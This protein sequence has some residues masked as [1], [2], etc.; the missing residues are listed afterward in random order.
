[1]SKYAILYADPC[2]DYDGREQHNK[3]ERNKSVG[4]HYN[5]MT[6]EELKKLKVPDITDSDALLFL[7]TSS[8]HLPQAIELMKS[9][10]FEY[11]T[12]AF[13]WDKQKVNVGYYTM[14]QCEICIVG[15]K[16]KIP[17]PRG[18]KNIRQFFSQERTR[19]SAKPAEF[20]NRIT[21]MF[22]EQKKVELFAR[23]KVD[24]W[25]CWGNEV[26]TAIKL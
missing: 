4:D 10:G 1:M 11:K 25:D 13:V 3:V 6:L 20:R 22:P 12:I 19:H 7:W 8:P 15:K 2:W 17:R 16:G 21:Q 9:W 14:S 24:G 26:E 5:T 23:E 18:A